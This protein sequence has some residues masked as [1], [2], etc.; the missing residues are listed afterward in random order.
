MQ[1]D[2]Y[3]W[4]IALPLTVGMLWLYFQPSDHAIKQVWRQLQRLESTGLSMLVPGRDVDDREQAHLIEHVLYWC[5][6][7]GCAVASGLSL[8][9][10]FGWM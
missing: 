2:P 5:A 9:S 7:S 1:I 4:L 8:A 3:G 10:C 6:L